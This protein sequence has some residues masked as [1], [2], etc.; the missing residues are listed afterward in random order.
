M[1]RRVDVVV[2]GAGPAGSSLAARLA[3]RGADVVLVDERVFPRSKPCGDCVS[4][5]AHPLLAELGVLESLRRAGAGALDGWRLRAPD[6]RW[7]QGR[8]GE[9]MGQ[10]KARGLAMPRRELDAA[11]LEAALLA[12]AAVRQGTRVVDLLRDGERVTGVRLRDGEGRESAQR[13]RLVA[14]ADGLR[15]TVS[16]RLGPV[17][18][19]RRRRLALVARYV[20]GPSAGGPP[21]LGEMRLSAEGCAGFAPIGEGRWNVTVVVPAARAPEISE[22][23]EAFLASRLEAYGLGP[24]LEGARRE[25][26]IEVTGPFELRPRRATAP[27]AFLLGDA[28]GYFDP[29]TG[30]GIYRALVTGRLGAHHALDTLEASGRTAAATERESRRAYRRELTRVLVPSRRVQRLVDQVIRHPALANAAA[31]LLAARPGLASLLVGVTGDLVRPGALLDPRRVATAFF[32]ARRGGGVPR[33]LEL[34]SRD[35][36]A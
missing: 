7:F 30:Q 3:R 9:G 11:L 27:G 20:D 1:G 18:A 19:G 21:V 12:G 23:R 10:R 8:F 6:G 16:R 35:A 17:H 4:P 2:V 13:A 36:H 24:R 15:S 5:G 28:A 32:D 25:G 26:E 33:S 29:F 34:E 31:R 22:N 14:G